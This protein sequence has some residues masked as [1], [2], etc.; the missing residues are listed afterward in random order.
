MAERALIREAIA[1]QNNIPAVLDGATPCPLVT[2]FPQVLREPLIKY[3]KA[4]FNLIGSLDI[5]Q[6]HYQAVY[7][8]SPRNV[9]PFCGMETMKIP[10]QLSE[11]EDAPNQDLDHYL[12]ISIYPLAGSN[13]K[14]L[15]PM[16]KDCNSTFKIA[17]DLLRREDGVRRAAFD[18]FAAPF[19]SIDL[20]GS[21]LPGPIENPRPVWRVNLSGGDPSKT[22]DEVWKIKRRLKDDVYSV[23]ANPWLINMASAATRRGIKPQDRNGLIA[24]LLQSRDDAADEAQELNGAAKL[25]FFEFLL[26]KVVADDPGENL[27]EFLM[28]LFEH[29][30]A[31]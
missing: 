13:L 22:W 12:P 25:A 29:A 24:L 19:S 3:F 28:A 30:I 23:Y 26:A 10:P 16:G 20:A 15:V 6:S 31:A 7:D 2:T 8:V 27:E 21:Q 18:P 5:R 14:N 11:D 1:T 17:A 9:C 4:G